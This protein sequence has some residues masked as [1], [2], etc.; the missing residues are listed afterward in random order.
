M[1]RFDLPPNPPL[2]YKGIEDINPRLNTKE[3]NIDSGTSKRFGFTPSS[4]K[5]QRRDKSHS[6]SL[7]QRLGWQNLQTFEEENIFLLTGHAHFSYAWW[8]MMVVKMWLVIWRE[9]VI[10]IFLTPLSYPRGPITWHRMALSSAV[11]HLTHTHTYTQLVS[12]VKSSSS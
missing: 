9:R 12:L 7:W 8:L 11:P 5:D 1:L 3:L 4:D 10:T 2:R 6:S